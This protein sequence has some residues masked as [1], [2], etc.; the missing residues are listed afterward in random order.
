MTTPNLTLFIPDK[1]DVERDAVALAWEAS[2]GPVLRIA[3]FWDPPALPR[4][5][6]R[7]YGHE[8]FCLVLQE[9]L[10]LLLVTPPDDLTL[11][12][13]ADLLQRA[14]V[15]RTLGDLPT[16]SYPAFV[17]SLIPKL[18]PSRVYVD[19][20]SLGDAAAGLAPGTEL[21]VSQPVDFVA[22]ARAFVLDGEVLDLAFYEGNGDLT[23]ARTCVEQIAERMPLPRALVVDVGALDDGRW[24]LVEFNAAWGAGLNGCRAELVVPAIA[25]ATSAA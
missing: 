24:V 25:A 10:D 2:F 20:G 9:K 19:S 23:S 5:L 17:K 18:I 22:E 21:L 11:Y 6:L 8:T 14:I 13:P 12:A 3:R 16:F 4:D 15:K 1:P 7:V